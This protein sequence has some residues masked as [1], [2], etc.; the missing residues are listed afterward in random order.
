MSDQTLF[1]LICVG[2]TL[3]VAIV[4]ARMGVESMR[5]TAIEKHAAYYHPMTGEFTWREL[6]ITFDAPAEKEGDK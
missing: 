3:M 2:C 5:K 4:G 1:I 6:P